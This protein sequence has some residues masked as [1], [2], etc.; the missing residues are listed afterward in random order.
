MLIGGKDTQSLIGGESLHS[1]EDLNKVKALEL[2]ECTQLENS[3]LHVR[4]RVLHPTVIE[5]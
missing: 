4:Y 1:F 5:R 3:F 2:I